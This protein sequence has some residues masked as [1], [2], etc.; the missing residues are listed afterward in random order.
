[1]LDAG[2]TFNHRPLIDRLS[3]FDLIID[4]LEP[5]A[6]A[7]TERRVS[8]LYADLRA[9][10]LRDDLADTLLCVSVLEHVG[11]NNAVY[12]VAAERVNDPD[13][14]ARSALDELRRVCR[15]DGRILNP[16]SYGR[17]MNVGWQRRFDA[18]AIDRLFD[19]L[20]VTV[21]VFEHDALGWQRSDVRAAVSCAYERGARAVLCAE[22]AP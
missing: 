14:S 16:V 12:G 2:S 18:S 20:E 1:V 4:T 6:Q 11:M 8:Y 7:F 3:G 15:P 10:P 5:E 19:G 17:A 9:P 21:T 22:I 13:A